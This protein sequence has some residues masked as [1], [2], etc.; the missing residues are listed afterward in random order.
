MTSYTKSLESVT[1]GFGATMTGGETDAPEC[2]AAAA[3]QV[4]FDFSNSVQ[5][6]CIN[7]F[8]A[9][10]LDPLRAKRTAIEE[11]EAAIKKRH[12]LKEEYDYYYEKV[13]KLREKSGDSAKTQEKIDRNEPKLEEAKVELKTAS[14]PLIA[15][16]NEVR[17]RESQRV[18]A[19]FTAP[20][21]TKPVR[22]VSR[23][24]LD[25]P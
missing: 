1:E 10:V 13:R 17:S 11:V 20:R 7:F 5:E 25:Q 12:K 6:A 9:N 8:N 16:F 3:T 23:L 19:G 2:D 15:L 4:V 21:S 22:W 18:L 14:A 24:I